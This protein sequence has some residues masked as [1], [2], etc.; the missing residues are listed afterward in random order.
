MNYNPLFFLL[1]I[2]DQPLIHTCSCAGLPSIARY[3]LLAN[4]MKI[5]LSL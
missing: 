3:Q 1:C 2:M 5:L 4:C